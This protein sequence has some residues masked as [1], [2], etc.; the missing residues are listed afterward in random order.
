MRT[1]RLQLRRW[2]DDD[3]A[4]FA[5]LNADPEVMRFFAGTMTRAESDAL[6]DRIERHFDEHGYGLW[7]VSVV[8]GDPFIGFVGLLWQHLDAPWAPAVEIGWRLARSAWGKGY[9]TEA[10]IAARDHAFGP[11]GLTDLVSMTTVTNLP[12]QAVMQRIGM[13][14]DPADD[15]LHPKLSPGHP[16]A[17]HVLYRLARPA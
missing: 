4:P 13:T 7:A 2:T 9:A 16:L 11:A 3:R 1:E 17:P 8:G 10:A 5:A 6:A 15:F 14:R 12:S